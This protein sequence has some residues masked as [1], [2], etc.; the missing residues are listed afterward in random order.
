M[1]PRLLLT[2]GCAALL[3]SGSAHALVNIDFQGDPAVDTLHVGDDGVLS[4]LGGTVWNDVEQGVDAILLDDEFGVQ[5]TANVSFIDPG[6]NNNDPDAVAANNNLQDSGTVAGFIL[7]GLNAGQSYDIAVYGGINMG[8]ALG[9]DGGQIF[10]FCAGFP[11]TYTLPG[12]QGTDYCLFQG[13]QP[14][15]FG[16]GVFGFDFGSIDGVITG[17]QITHSP[18]SAPEPALPAMLIGALVAG[19][20]V[21]NRR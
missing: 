19:A 10:G 18:T 6:F 3:F 21:R 14:F 9:H 2:L 15:N 7:W 13:L 16:G 8:F 20:A 4:S 12:V 5:T 17:V 1:L 11:L